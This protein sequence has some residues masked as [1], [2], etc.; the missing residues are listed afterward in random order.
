MINSMLEGLGLWMTPLVC[1]H[2]Y[3]TLSVCWSSWNSVHSLVVIMAGFC[4]LQVCV[5]Q[6][7]TANEF[8]VRN[9]PVCVDGVETARFANITNFNIVDPVSFI[10]ASEDVL[11]SL[12]FI[13]SS[14]P[15]VFYCLQ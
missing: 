3:H 8:G 7:P 2:H 11:V 5:S 12:I 6:C 15:F 13:A 9:S 10:S 4:W 14:Y 1:K